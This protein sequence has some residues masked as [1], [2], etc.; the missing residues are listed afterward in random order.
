MRIGVCDDLQADRNH[1]ISLIQAYYRDRE[2]V[3]IYEYES[4]EELLHH[5]RDGWLT[6]LFLDVYMGG[7]SGMEAAR[8][9]RET[10]PGCMVIFT[11]TSPDHAIDSY[12]V[13]ASDYLLKPFGREEVAAALRWCEE[14]AD[15]LQEITVIAERERR[16]VACREIFYIE[17]YG[18]ASIIH[19]AREQI[20][21][22]RALGEL[23]AEIGGESFLRCHR[24]YL[25]NMRHIRRPEG[26][27]FLLLNQERVPIAQES[28]AR[29]RQAFFEWTFRQTWENGRDGRT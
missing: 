17:V 8:K 5:W 29:V 19:T 3:E 28:A 24:S 21:T 6:C 12:E 1:L 10:D 15:D 2:G 27:D 7:L 25:V 26:R 9:I 18:R 4:A 14:T 13:R 20:R 11:T 22:N 23:E 16:Q